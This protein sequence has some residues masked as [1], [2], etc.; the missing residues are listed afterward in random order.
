[1]VATGRAEV[2][3]DPVVA[4]WDILPF[5]P[6]LAEAGGVL[7]SWPGGAGDAGAGAGGPP[8]GSAVATNAALDSAVRSLLGES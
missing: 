6:I 3:L 7:T 8:V 4:P 5:V 1:M 2:A